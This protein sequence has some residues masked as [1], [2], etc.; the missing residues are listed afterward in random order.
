MSPCHLVTLLIPVTL[1]PQCL[2]PLPVELNNITKRFGPLT[3]NRRV[4]ARCTR[5]KSHCSAT[6]G[7]STLM[8]DSLRSLSTRRRRSAHQWPAGRHPLAEVGA[9]GIGMLVSQHFALNY[10][11]SVTE[12]DSGAEQRCAG[13]PGGWARGSPK[14]LLPAG[15]E[16]DPSALIKNLSWLDQRR[17]W[18]SSKRSIA[19][20]KS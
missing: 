14:R 6:T 15:I 19:T 1:S 2:I 12:C 18:K 11:L 4:S 9:H 13:E 16:I 20:P 3:A 5:A 7:K 8:R 10:P 17:A